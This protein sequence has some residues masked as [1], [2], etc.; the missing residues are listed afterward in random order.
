MDIRTLMDSGSWGAVAALFRIKTHV[1]RTLRDDT[2]RELA[3]RDERNERLAGSHDAVEYRPWTD[4]ALTIVIP[5][6]L[7]VPQDPWA[8]PDWDTPT[9]YLPE[10]SQV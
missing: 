1:D 7:P 3:L 10:L 8:R 2:L 6:L 5:A 4:S 9:R